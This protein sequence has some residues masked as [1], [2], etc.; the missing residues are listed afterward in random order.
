MVEQVVVMGEGAER[1]LRGWW[2]RVMG[3]GAEGVRGGG[4]GSKSG[5]GWEVGRGQGAGAYR[6]VRD[7][8]SWQS[9]AFTMT[10]SALLA[11]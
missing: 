2:E 3:E 6:G 11:R 4:Q 1:V 10:A 5:C 7:R 9:P 8:E